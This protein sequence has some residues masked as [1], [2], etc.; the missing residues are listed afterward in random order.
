MRTLLA[1]VLLVPLVLAGCVDRLAERQAFLS[2]LLGQSE[3]TLIRS[4]GVPVQV[5]ETNG[6][7]FLGYQDVRT[8]VY[9]G[10]SLM[11]PYGP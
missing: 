5:Y 3:E 6:H 8:Y 11:L 10:G 1:A 9:P 4:M 2:S 7:R